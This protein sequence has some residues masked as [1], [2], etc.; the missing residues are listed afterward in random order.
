MPRQCLGIVKLTDEL[1]VLYN[2]KVHS[3]EVFEKEWKYAKTVFG[4]SKVNRL[5]NNLI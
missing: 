3:R 4:H 1:A 5:I 2:G